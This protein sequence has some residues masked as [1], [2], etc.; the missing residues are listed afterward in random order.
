MIIINNNPKLLNHNN[1]FKII[2]KIK[3]YF[4]NYLISKDRDK[5]KLKKFI[6][7]Y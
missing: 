6:N 1:K 5:L 2:C 7:N 3:L 4:K